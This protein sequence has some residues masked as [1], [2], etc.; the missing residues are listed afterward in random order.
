MLADLK[1]SI[2]KIRLNE[3]EGIFA[4]YEAVVNSIQ[5]NSKNIEVHIKTKND[6][7]ISLTGTSE[8][9][10]DQIE[11]ID[12]GEG[13]TKENFESFKKINSTHKLK[14]GGKGVGR[15]SWLAIF[16]DVKV[17][18]IYKE[19][20][21]YYLREFKFNLINE[22]VEINNEKTNIQ[23][24]KTKIILANPTSKY[25]KF[26]PKTAPDMCEKILYH[27]LG[28]L[29]EGVFEITIKDGMNSCKCKEKYRQELEKDVKT[30]NF[31]LK[32]YNFEIIHIPISKNKLQSHEIAFT[33]NTREVKRKRLDRVNELLS[34]CLNIE[35]EEKYILAYIKGE[36]LDQNVT[37]DRNDFLFKNMKGNLFLK[38]KEI[39]EQVAKEIINIYDKEVKEIIKINKKKIEDFLAE[40]PYY[41]SLYLNDD[42]ILKDINPKSSSEDIEMKFESFAR[43]KRKETTSFIKN[44]E[45]V[46]DYKDKLK[47]TLKNI[48]SLNQYELSKYVIHRK[49]ITEI[50]EKILQKKDADDKYH[51]EEDLHNLIFPMR[52]SSDEINY[53]DHNLWLI[54]DRLAYNKFLTSDKINKKILEG[55]DSRERIDLAAIYDR[56]ITFSDRGDI[57]EEHSNVLIV[58]F[59]RPGREDF[60]VADLNNQ[61][62]NYVDE[63]KDKKV[64]TDRGQRIEVSK[65]SIFNIFIICEITENLEKNLLR[66]GYKK[67]IEGQGYYVFNETYNALIQVISLNKVLKDSKLRNKIF[68]KKL[69]I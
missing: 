64:K 35:N 15:L 14:I 38:E 29:I 59:K 66:N 2:N 67:I 22:I 5:S 68:F 44:I 50:L 37:E 42:S 34:V 18:S 32:D 53:D 17:E 12:D 54:D 23:T 69:G 31:E 11:I 8:T 20:G 61:V 40:N 41:N 58:E 52:K 39:I 36:Y 25:A 45:L 26:L 16:E 63:L 9:V 65:N 33:A 30:K 21:E 49:I 56:N 51:Y 7:Q 4:I 60:T 27:C 1:G 13:F 3:Q 19:N 46:G 24:E 43:E 48:E 57:E 55:S 10:I 62:L 6:T 47:N 28:Y